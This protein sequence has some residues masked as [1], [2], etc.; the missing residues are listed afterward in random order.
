[1]S[2]PKGGNR[3]AN[4]VK[5]FYKNVVEGKTL[6]QCAKEIGVSRRMVTNYK[7]SSNFRQMAI[8]YLEDSTLKGLSGTISRLV[9]ALD[10]EK[11]IT[12]ENA[13]GEVSVTKI[14]DQRT[15]MIAL[16]EVIEIYGLHAPEQKDTTVRI[17]ISSDEDLFRQIDDAQRA[18]RFVESHPTGSDGVE[19][20]SGEQTGNR[21]DFDT[22]QR[23]LLQYVAV[24]ESQ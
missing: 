22:R 3:E 15:R 6:A 18:C 19:V 21:G 12:S 24:Q 20:A 10:A 11:V 1:M 13:A 17:S 4:E 9:K 8:E 5:V 2:R 7:G 16:Q 23:A 14:P